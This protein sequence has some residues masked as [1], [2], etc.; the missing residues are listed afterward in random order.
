MQYNLENARQNI[1]AWLKINDK[2]RGWLTKELGHKN[3]ATENAIR[4]G[5]TRGIQKNWC[6]LWR[7]M[8]LPNAEVL[9][10]RSELFN[11][12]ADAQLFAEREGRTRLFNQPETP[13]AKAIARSK[14]LSAFQWLKREITRIV[15]LWNTREDDSEHRDLKPND[16]WPGE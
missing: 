10:W 3:M 2:P 5:I 1:L 11:A 9:G 15:G 7:I 13:V 14:S 12:E 6:S 16:L 8:G 4:N